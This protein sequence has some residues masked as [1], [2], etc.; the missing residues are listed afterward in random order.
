MNTKE[1]A[2]A[3]VPAKPAELVPIPNPPAGG[4]WLWDGDANVWRRRTAAAQPTTTTQE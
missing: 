3:S 4:S 1:T 2:P